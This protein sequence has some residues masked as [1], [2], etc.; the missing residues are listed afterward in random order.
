M[1]QVARQSA[2]SQLGS[3]GAAFWMS[4]VIEMCERLSY[5]GLR[6]VLPVYM[7]LAVEDG[8][9]QFTNIQKG[10]IYA[11]WAAIQSFVPVF[12]GGYADRFGYRLTVAI[13][14][15]INICGFVTMAY[16]Q[17][18]ASLAT[19]GASVG[20]PG[21]PA[22][23][24]S[25]LLGACLLACGTA[26]FK[27]GIQGLIASQITAETG[28][29]AWSIFYQVVN[30]GGFLG[31][32]LAG[33]MRLLAWRYVFFAS[34]AIASLNLLWLLFIREPARERKSAD[35][36]ELLM[37]AV[38]GVGGIM[39]PRLFS[40]LAIF[41][42][43]WAMFYQLYDMLPVFI[44]DWVDS[45]AIYQGVVV[46]LF[47]IFG[48]TPPEAWGGNV[49]QEHM[50]NVN[51][52][53]IMF[54]VSIVGYLAGGF[55]SMTNMT[56]GIVI[57][58][59]GILMLNTNQGTG[60]LLAIVIFSIGEM[61]ASPTKM[62]YVA[63]LATPDKKALYLGYVNATVGIGWTIGSWIAGPLYERTGDKVVLA[64]EYLEKTVGLGADV[65]KAIPKS[66]V[67]PRLATELGKT[68]R[69]VQDM[70]WAANSPTEVW[71]RFAQIGLTSMVG[72]ILFDQLTRRKLAQ[73]PLILIGLVGLITTVCYGPWYGVIFV[74]LMIG[75]EVGER[76]LGAKDTDTAWLPGSIAM[77]VAIGIGVAWKVYGLLAA[78]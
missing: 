30:I 28:S 31:P 35:P 69:E 14:V 65:V 40:F 8:G 12:S 19:G 3:F 51:S 29:L 32:Y 45:S 44:E 42:G 23:Y 21:H 4:N 6:V 20:V 66:E 78:G 11:V 56:V 48:S 59:A 47:A 70:L 50:I 43:F 58:A 39:E 52:L 24:Y 77:G 38:R 68:P 76:V 46:P 55:R 17:E 5:Y 10:E 49:S 37:V 33:V 73:E 25:F 18:I 27:P 13:S 16:A 1:N 57:S 71:F 15:L 74:A 9:P 41:S 72:M 67:M 62:R 36:V 7:L 63:D 60:I 22:L 26:I 75:R 34:A 61:L 64:R 54:T 2:W 53:M